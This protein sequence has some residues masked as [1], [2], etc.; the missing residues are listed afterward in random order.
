MTIFDVIKKRYEA[1][2]ICKN[3]NAVQEVSIPKGTLKSQWF[4]DGV[5]KCNVCG[6]YALEE[7][8]DRIMKDISKTKYKERLDKPNFDTYSE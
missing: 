6:C 8:V 4:N 5:G 7:F 2:A 1:K 3:C